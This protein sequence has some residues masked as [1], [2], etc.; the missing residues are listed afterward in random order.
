VK[1]EQLIRL[2]GGLRAGR[3]EFYS[4]Q[5]QEIFLF[6][7]ASKLAFRPTQAII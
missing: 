7:V 4:R 1:Q 5:E 6:S 2:S 3:A